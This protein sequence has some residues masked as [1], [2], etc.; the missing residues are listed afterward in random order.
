MHNV[1]PSSF[2]ETETNEKRFR[3]LIE[4]NEG[5]IALI[6]AELNYVFRSSSTN[7][8]SG[9]DTEKFQQLPVHLLHP[10]DQENAKQCIAAA[11]QQPNIPIPYAFRF[12]HANG[13][14]IWLEGTITNKLDDADIKG[15]VLNLRDTTRQ[16]A[17]EQKINKLNRLYRFISQINQMIV[18]VKD[19]DTLFREACRI[20]VEIG[21]FRM[22]WIGKVDAGRKRVI[23]VVHE[24]EGGKFLDRINIT[25]QEE[26][27]SGNGP[28]GRA[29]RTNE[30]VYCNDIETAPEMAPWR[31]GA[32]EHHF[33]SSIS[34]PIRKFGEVT[35][36]F[37]AYADTK[38]F[39]DAEEIALL[40][41]STGDIS[42]AL[43]QLEKDR[44]RRA[45]EHN[46]A[47]SEKRYQTLAEVAP[48]GIF[49]TDPDG[50]TT[51]VN[52]RWSEISGLSREK[53]LGAGWLKAVH[54]DDREQL[55]KEWHAA[56]KTSIF[57][58]SEYRFLRPDG[59]IA[60]VLG[61]AIPEKGADNKTIGYVGTITDITE[62]RKAEE[63][64]VKTRDEMVK[65]RHLSDSIINS[66]PGVFY[67]YDTAGKF[68]RWNRNFELVTGYSSEE[69]KRIHPLDLFDEDQKALLA[70][71]IAGTFEK[72]EESVQAEFMLKSGAKIPYYFT[73]KTVE[74]E[75]QTCLMGVG[76]D[77]SEKV[78]AQE[79]V[80]ETT[81]RLRQL[82]AHLQGIREE[83]RKRIG[84][85]IHDELGQQLTAIKMDIAWIDKKTPPENA[86]IKRKIRNMI[87]LLD[88]SNRSIRRI[89]SELRPGILDNRDLLEAMEW[90]G[91]QFTANTG[92]PVQVHCKETHLE[93]P[94][95][96]STSL[97]RVY[98]EALTNI[99]R[100]AAATEVNTS[101]QRDG[102]T[103]VLTISDNGKGFDPDAV[104][105]NQSFGIMGMKERIL[106]LNGSFNLKSAPGEGT[107]IHIQ[108][109]L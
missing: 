23:P 21:K 27:P 73:G 24:G 6:D 40:E 91:I 108:V 17:A 67:L 82:T 46:L 89:L 15:L 50:Q 109:P 71:K 44:Q 26:A 94:E 54:P 16:R 25:L 32:R 30:T 106:S 97:F 88:T 49:H 42:F 92:I 22:A 102:N 45:A 61:Q 43:E 90:L 85:E 57:S 65:E 47:E 4:H 87:E 35:G 56:A 60:W 75:G 107:H 63:A 86:D 74:Y 77:F 80:R 101:F 36:S 2:H 19:E 39:F 83:E 5:I 29:L 76:I 51:Y 53:A 78:K 68:L 20:A 66:L 95:N 64:V 38:D 3:A 9:W 62:R 52:P 72:G 58:V 99:M 79:Q 98:Q 103:I 14:Y 100:Y 34:V 28:T 7:R 41:E 55:K 69:M 104:Q 33:K 1:S 10:E 13:H 18:K 93:L 37:V 11:L 31:E 8:I 59:S 84:R 48:V 96:I 12:Q 81:A 105:P 70:E